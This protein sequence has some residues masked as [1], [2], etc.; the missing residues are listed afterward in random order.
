MSGKPWLSVPSRWIE[1]GFLEDLL[2]LRGQ[3]HLVVQLYLAHVAELKRNSGMGLVAPMLSI[4]VHVALL[5]SVMSLVFNEPI[6]VFIPFFVISLCLWEVF[7]ISIANSA[8]ANERT[9][10]YLS[11]PH[12]S[13]YIVHLVNALDQLVA[14][15]LKIVAAML[16]ILVI[17]PKIL[18]TANYPGLFVGVILLLCVMFAWSLPMSYIFD[19][20]RILRGFLPQIL[21]ATYLVSPILWDPQRVSGHRWVVDLNPVF[22]LIEL[23][24]SPLLRGDWPLLSIT[25]AVGTILTGLAVSALVFRPNRDLVVY[26][27][28][29]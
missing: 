1:R 24:R 22:H 7:A 19:R 14:V 26:R 18:V 9:V 2:A 8:N 21:F 13:G 11:F 17:N 3:R 23:A 20:F 5:G 4:L 12:V 29:A 6:E 10:T 15:G 27:W 25:V 28:V 16:I